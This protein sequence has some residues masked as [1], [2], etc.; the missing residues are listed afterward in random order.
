MTVVA[1][2][3]VLDLAC[4]PRLERD[5]FL[6]SES[7]RMAAAMLD[8]WPSWPGPAMLLVGPP[9]SGKTHLAALW[10]NDVGASVVSRTLSPS[11]WDGGGRCVLVEDCDRC[12][13]DE[14]DLFHAL[15]LAAET[16]GSLLLTARQ[17]AMAWGLA[18]ADLVSRLRLASTA[19]L[20]PPDDELL[21]A[22]LVKLF[23]DRQIRVDAD[24]VGYAARHCDQSMESIMRFVELV[25]E[26]ALSHGRRITKPLAAATLATMVSH[27]RD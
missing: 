8:S 21:R 23:A 15:N 18:T 16:G 3:L 22:V 24:V 14:A 27:D 13:P 2:Q 7:N 5:D 6:V 11:L 10:A 1:R 19:T 12:R 9:G 20:S 25:D 4:A 26:A 17:P